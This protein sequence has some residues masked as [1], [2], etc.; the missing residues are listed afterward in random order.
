MEQKCPEIKLYKCFCQLIGIVRRKGEYLACLDGRY[1]MF[2]IN[3]PELCAWLYEHL[4]T[5]HIKLF[6]FFIVSLISYV[7]V[8]K[9]ERS[10]EM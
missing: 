1:K 5:S 7:S 10:E 3:D 8:E 9:E 4:T 2:H 6:S